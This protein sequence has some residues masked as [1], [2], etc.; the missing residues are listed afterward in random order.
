MVMARPLAACAWVGKWLRGGRGRCGVEDEKRIFKWT[1]T[2]H[3]LMSRNGGALHCLARHVQ[4]EPPASRQ[5]QQHSRQFASV[6]VQ[7][8]FACRRLQASF[9]SCS[10][11]KFQPSDRRCRRICGHLS[12][13]PQPNGTVPN[14]HQT[15]E[16]TNS[17][18]A[19]PPP[20]PSPQMQMSCCVCQRR[21]K[22][23]AVIGGR[24]NRQH[25][26]LFWHAIVQVSLIS[27]TCKWSHV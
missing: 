4:M 6:T 23:Q 17:L 12:S 13:Q 20:P 10:C 25:N 1:S 16:N 7:P 24:P 5:P 15:S 2:E 26:F 22:E 18:V 8:F 27:P 14:P 21:E 11:S 9:F 3:S 19:D